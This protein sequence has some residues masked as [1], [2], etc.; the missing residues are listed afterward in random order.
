MENGVFHFLSFDSYSLR[1]F[2]ELSS[3]LVK[4][5]VVGAS[6]RHLLSHLRISSVELLVLVY[7]M[8][9][10]THLIALPLNEAFSFLFHKVSVFLTSQNIFATFIKKG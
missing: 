10:Q 6:G 1:E 4:W 7:A 8:Q 9:T 2:V 3:E 5:W